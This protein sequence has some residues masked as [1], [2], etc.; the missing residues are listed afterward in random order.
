MNI[1]NTALQGD[2]WSQMKLLPFN[3]YLTPVISVIY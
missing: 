3:L 1:P 2:K